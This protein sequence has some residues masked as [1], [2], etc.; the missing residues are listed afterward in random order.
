MSLPG[1]AR[2]FLPRAV[3]P[4][5]REA[6]AD[7]PVIVVNGARQAGKTTLA[8]SL[9]SGGIGSF[10]T[11]DDP[12]T[13]DAAQADPAGFLRGRAEPLVI[14]EIQRAPDLLLAIKASI[15][16]DRRPGR[17]VLTGST[18]FLTVPTL[19]ESLA[20]RV[21]IVE[22]WPFSQ[23]ELGGTTD[24]FID[25]LFADPA[26]TQLKASAPDRT[27][28]LRR[29]SVGG[30]PEAVSRSTDRAR[31]RWF[32]SYFTTVIQRDISELGD[33]RKI[34]E[35]PR[36]V[37]LLSARTAS[38]L[39]ISDLSRDARLKWETAR[40]YM[41]L[42]ET[43]FLVHRLP[44]W[45]T[46]LTSRMTKQAKVFLT[47]SGLVAFLL[48]TSAQ[49]LAE[50]GSPHSGQLFE[51]FVVNELRKQ[52]TWAET[53][54]ALHHYR[55]RDGVEVDVVVEARDGR[56]AALEVKSSGRVQKTDL[57]GLRLL[58]DRLGSRLGQ[59]LVLYCGEE[60][61]ELEDRLFAVPASTLWQR[62]IPLVSL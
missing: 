55:D 18:R 5:L 53:D 16:R 22:L 8:T 20:G 3:E 23:G 29:A 41:A 26:W 21:E 39:N 50:Q 48:G 42:L 32:D 43:V 52:V 19:S 31:R 54:V 58:R 38:V 57:R 62:E 36:L 30:F 9:L 17:F 6:L 40:E 61:R 13:R 15:D 46:N 37:K 12:D 1:S 56:V 2:R 4:R 47:D 49:A 7:T 27:E 34:E 25:R 10:T 45:S 59:G 24:G 51:T 44:A 35:L 60:A 14:D 28:Y 11:L 33:V